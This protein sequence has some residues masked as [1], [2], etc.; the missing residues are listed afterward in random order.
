MGKRNGRKPFHDEKKRT[1]LCSGD[2]I[3]NITTL[4]TWRWPKLKQ[5][6]RLHN[7]MSETRLHYK[8]EPLGCKLVKPSTHSNN[9][10]SLSSFMHSNTFTEKS[11]ANLVLSYWFFGRGKIFGEPSRVGSRFLWRGEA[12]P[13]WVI[14]GEQSQIDKIQILVCAQESQEFQSPQDSL[15]L[16]NSPTWHEHRV[17]LEKS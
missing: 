5:T 13:S 17:R 8:C 9:S 10:V 4:S 2:P 6:N 12:S 1:W 16:R 3:V 15:S 7:P 11:K 14:F